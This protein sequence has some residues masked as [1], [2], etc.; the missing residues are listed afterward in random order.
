MTI[1][2]WRTIRSR[3]HPETF[4][5]FYGKVFNLLLAK[6]LATTLAQ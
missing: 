6:K 1:A 5:S 4:A 3:D 2:S